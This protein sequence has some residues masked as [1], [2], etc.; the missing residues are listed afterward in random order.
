MTSVSGCC[1]DTTTPR[2]ALLVRGVGALCLGCHPVGVP[3]GPIPEKPVK[4][5][6]SGC[7]VDEVAA[8]FGAPAHEVHDKRLGELLD[9]H[10]PPL[11]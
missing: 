2:I 8:K 9:A 7:D 6:V 11:P 5:G 4:I 3:T 10:S 1:P